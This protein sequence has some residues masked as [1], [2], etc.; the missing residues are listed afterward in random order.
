M[1]KFIVCVDFDGTIIHGDDLQ[2]DEMILLPNCKESLEEIKGLGGYIIISSVRSTRKGRET[3]KNLGWVDPFIQ[4]KKFL[5]DS[6]IPYDWIDN[7]SIGKVWADFYVDDKSVPPFKEWN[8]TL[9][10]IKDEINKPDFSSMV[11]KL[12]LPDK[13]GLEVSVTESLKWYSFDLK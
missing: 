7:G 13:E 2:K 11:N 1:I 6:D 10:Y 4:M 8:E 3:A 9:K 5:D 12:G